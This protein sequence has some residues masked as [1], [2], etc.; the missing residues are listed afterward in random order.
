[1]NKLNE[2][3][4]QVSFV[5]PWLL[6]ITLGVSFFLYGFSKFPLP[7]E[8]LLSFGFSQFVAVLVPLVEV[9]GGIGIILTGFISGL[10]GQLLTRALGLVLSVLMIFALVLAHSDWLIN[11][12]LFKNIQVYLLV[13]S[14]HFVFKPKG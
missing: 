10:W 6:R 13:V 11:A 1:M 5:G 2:Y 7:S 12:E 9:I 4:D 3:I 14:L 8:L